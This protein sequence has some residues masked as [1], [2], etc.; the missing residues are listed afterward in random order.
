MME[1]SHLLKNSATISEFLSSFVTMKKEARSSWSLNQWAGELGYSSSGTLSRIISGSREANDETLSRLKNYFQFNDEDLFLFE[2]LVY[3]S[4]FETSLPRISQ[5]LKEE[6]AKI[7][8]RKLRPNVKA[9]PEVFESIE[10]S[11]NAL[12]FSLVGT[13]DFHRTTEHLTPLVSLLL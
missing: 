10:S 5:I 1:A 11:S 6:R 8:D 13:L 2:S 9:P 12:T 7:L 3:S 4:K